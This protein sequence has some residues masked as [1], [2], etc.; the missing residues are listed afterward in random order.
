MVAYNEDVNEWVAHD[1]AIN[2]RQGQIPVVLRR[3]ML[4]RGRIRWHL[5]AR[6][7]EKLVVVVILKEG[8]SSVTSQK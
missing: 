8:S 6:V 2:R 5:Q 4:R 1:E 3:M 7:M